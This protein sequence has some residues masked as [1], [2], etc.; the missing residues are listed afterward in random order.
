MPAETV[1]ETVTL[2]RQAVMDLLVEV[3]GVSDALAWIAGCFPTPLTEELEKVTS[4]I[5]DQVLSAWPEDD[6]A[7]SPRVDLNEAGH[8]RGRELL[9]EL[10]AVDA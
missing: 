8:K 4:R 3:E 1:I 2:D 5:A 6:D 9:A 10:V 7:P